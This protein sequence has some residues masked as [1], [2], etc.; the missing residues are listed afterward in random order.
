MESILFFS[1]VF[2]ILNLKRILSME[3]IVGL[4]YNFRVSDCPATIFARKNQTE[5][6]Q[7]FKFISNLKIF[8]TIQ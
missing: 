2:C 8:R 1:S 5:L 3:A 6:F 4:P 7:I